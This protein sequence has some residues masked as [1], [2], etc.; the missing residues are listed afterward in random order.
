MLMIRT[1]FVLLALCSTTLLGQ[2]WRLD[3][4]RLCFDRG[5]DNGAMNVHQSWI[6]VSDYEIPLI[7]G[8]AV[9]VFIEPGSAE[10]QVTSTIPYEPNSK[11]RQACKSRVVEL[12]L[13]PNE[14]RTFSIEPA[15]KGSAY[16]CGWHIQQVHPALSKSMKK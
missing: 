11:N 9:C 2:S 7:G 3:R 4:A 10:V 6:H 16:I 15:S 5:E 13:A 1:C 8:Q 12:D 14:N